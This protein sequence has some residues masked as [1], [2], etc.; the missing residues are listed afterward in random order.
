M[1]SQYSA[2]ERQVARVLS[3]FPT[4]KKWA[5]ASYGRLAY[6]LSTVHDAPYEARGKVRDV[7]LPGITTF[8]G[9]YDKS[10][11]SADGW[12]LCHATEIPSH[13]LPQPW[14]PVSIQV[15]DFRS[16]DLQRPVLSV[17]THC[18]NWQQ[19]A[20]AQW[21]DGDHFIFNDF[22]PGRQRYISRVYSVS[23]KTEVQRYDQ[24]VQDARGRDYFLSL[25]YRRL[26]TLRPDYGYIN[27]P[28]LD[29]EALARLDDDG[30]RY[31]DGPSGAAR[32]LYSLEA[33][34]KI[35]PKPIFDQAQHKVNHIM[36]SPSGKRFIFLHRYFVEN[37][38][39]DRLMLGMV[40]GSGLG[41]LCDHDMVSHCFWADDRTLLCYLRGPSGKDGYY[42]VDVDTATLRSF[43]G[44]SL[45]T[46]GD[47]HPHVHGD[48]FI[49]DT[50]P[51][52]NRMQHLMIGNW[53]DGSVQSLGSFYHSF[54]FGGQTR[55]DLHPR[56]SQDGRQV[57]F[58]S[59][60]GG[61]RRLCFVELQ[62]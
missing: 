31:I 2:A 24:P 14:H 39:F 27:L 25:N 26:Q 41:L 48:R 3:R 6:Y 38:K 36:I 18:F 5:K 59:V 52:R 47:G 13:Q 16:R 34:C 12:L 30:I 35:S 54:R 9:Y 32:M 17:E 4:V 51:D 42:L 11:V 29:Q 7:G 55:C 20:R 28:A 8:F 37:R 10:P 62:S 58:D 43:A 40:D 33:V 1:A 45:D 61:T 22:D 50:Y 21:L 23:Q 15:F 60:F 49:T 57:F 46:M 44:G 19:G 53:K 56:F